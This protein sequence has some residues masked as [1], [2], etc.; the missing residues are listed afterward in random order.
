MATI[1][2]H[3]GSTVHRAHN[4]RDQRVVDKQ[5]HIDQ[6]G[7]HETWKDETLSHA[8]HRLFDDAVARYNAKQTREER[9]IGSY[10][11]KIQQDGKKH[12]AYEM[13]VG[14]YGSGDTETNK[15]ILRE[16]VEGWEQRNPNLELIGAYYHADEEG[17]PHVHLDYIPVVHDCKRGLETQTA[18][19]KSLEAMGFTT[20]GTSNTAQMQWEASENKAL[21][22]ICWLHGVEVEH[23]E[24]DKVQHLE[25]DVYKAQQS[26]ERTEATLEALEGRVED[27]N[28][29]IASLQDKKREAEKLLQNAEETKEMFIDL[30]DIYSAK[31][32]IAIKKECDKIYNEIRPHM[33]PDEQRA[34]ENKDFQTLKNLYD[35]RSAE[36]EI[37]IA[38][39]GLKYLI[40]AKNPFESEEP[41]NQRDEN[42]FMRFQE[43]L[44]R[45]LD[46]LKSKKRPT[47]EQLLETYREH[48]AAREQVRSEDER[49][50]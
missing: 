7:I 15:Q 10:L 38:K 5:A 31:K 41:Q 9:K 12:P 21:E 11:A 26:L 46:Y 4:I 17:E 48:M 20:K 13:I 44:E 34:Y 3:N 16:F 36:V 1:S 19:N 29:D 42:F 45:I 28:R 35:E 40:A 39:K 25:T 23:P 24:R 32:S 37:P 22:D 33:L 14:V 49:G 27:L 18:L 6:N 30:L 2:T 47:L 8:Y 50:R 43:L